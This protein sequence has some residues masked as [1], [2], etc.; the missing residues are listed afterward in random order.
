MPKVKDSGTRMREY[1]SLSSTGKRSTCDECGHPELR[2]AYQCR[3]APV[4]G[5]FCRRVRCWECAGAFRVEKKSDYG[6]FPMW[7][8]YAIPT[9]PVCKACRAEEVFTET[10]KGYL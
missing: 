7:L 3:A 2:V 1:W 9:Y 6:Q 10:K 5:G 8:Y 4:S